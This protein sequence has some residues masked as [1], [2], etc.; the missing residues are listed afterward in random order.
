V[1]NGDHLTELL[2]TRLGHDRIAAEPEA[3]DELLVRC[4]RQQQRSA[5]VQRIQALLDELPAG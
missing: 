2:C 5:D 4:C 3:V 1:S